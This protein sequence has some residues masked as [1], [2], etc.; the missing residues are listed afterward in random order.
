MEIT[1][2]EQV[3]VDTTMHIIMEQRYHIIVEEEDLVVL[4]GV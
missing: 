1:L 3:R 2:Q 4:E